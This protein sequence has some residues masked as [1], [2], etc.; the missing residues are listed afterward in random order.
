[1]G[2]SDIFVD[3][4]GLYALVDKNDTHHL[5]ARDIVGAASRAGRM[6]LLTDYVI[7]EATTLAR[8]RSGGPMA[9]RVLDLTERSAAMVVERIDVARFEAT[10]AFF[11]KHI[12]H[13]YSFT[14]C[15]SFVLM[16]EL[17]LVRSLTSDRH[18]REAGFEPLLGTR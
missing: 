16:R 8:A 15:S 12:D 17:R 3:T 4:S 14:D 9:L 10:K 2:R 11:R 18:F 5:A 1:M 7:G 6:L 13:G